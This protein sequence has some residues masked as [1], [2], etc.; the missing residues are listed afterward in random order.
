MKIELQSVNKSFGHRQVLHNINVELSSKNA[1]VITG[2]NGSGK[3]TLIK[4]ICG[5]LKPTSGQIILTNN[6]QIIAHENY[7]HYLGLVAP[8]LELYDQLSAYENILFFARLYR[9]QNI[10]TNISILFE[11]L[12]LNGYER[13][14]VKTY[15][16]GMKQRLK[17]V[18]ALLSRPEI[19]LIDEPTTNLDQDGIKRIYRIMEEQRKQGI[20]IYTTNDKQDIKS[21]DKIIELSL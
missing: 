16:S 6:G 1:L 21:G 3:S 9:I 7:R 20:L 19:L 5:L 2:P 14:Q 18:F 4:L 17:Y 11:K 10:K 8:Y 13:E 15:S 12:N